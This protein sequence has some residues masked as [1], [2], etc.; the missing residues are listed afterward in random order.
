MEKIGEE[1][2]EVQHFDCAPRLRLRIVKWTGGGGR[3]TRMGS[4]F[5]QKAIL[6]GGLGQ[7]C[8]QRGPVVASFDREVVKK[9]E[10]TSN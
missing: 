2:V 8:G 4:A 6:S 1:P 5:W 7:L 9:E 10:Q 3:G